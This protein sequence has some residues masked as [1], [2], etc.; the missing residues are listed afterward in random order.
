MIQ[1]QGD[2]VLL[3]SS[4]HAAVIADIVAREGRWRLAG[5]IDPERPRGSMWNGLEVLGGDGDIGALMASRGI[6]GGIVAIGDNAL[7]ERVTR[8]ISSECPSFL[9]ATAVHPA[10]AVASSVSV[11]EGSVVMAGAVINPGSTV[12]RGC[13][14][15][16]RSS[17][18][19]DSVIE[20]F[21]SLAPG[22]TTGGRVRIGRGS[23]IGLGALIREAAKIGESTVVGAGALGLSDLPSG[24]VAYGVPARVVR[25]RQPGDK[26]LR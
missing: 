20:D 26:Y 17:L 2:I 9:F 13:I 1:I 3:G 15:N 18:D 21:A 5:V 16:T 23:A 7:R 22:A 24:V 4:G 19:H 6:V 14:L 10:A 12:G 11:G 25:P 8:R